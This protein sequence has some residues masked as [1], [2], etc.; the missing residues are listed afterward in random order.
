MEFVQNPAELTPDQPQYLTYQPANPLLTNLHA[1]H[2][3]TAYLIQTS[4]AA[5]L[6]VTGE[7]LPPHIEWKPNAF[8]F[9]GFHLAAGEEPTFGDYFG[10][11]PEFQNPDGTLGE[12]FVLNNATG[13]WQ[14]VIGTE[15]MLKGEGVWVYCRGSSQ[16]TGPFRL[17]LEQG[18]AL[19]FGTILTTQ[20]IELKNVG[21]PANPPLSLQ[22]SSA[23][24]ASSWLYY[25]VLD[26]QSGQGQWLPFPQ[27]PALSLSVETGEI[28]RLRLGVR[29][30]ALSAGEDIGTNLRIADGAGAEVL[31]PVSATGVDFSGLWVGQ[32][33]LDRVNEIHNAGDPETLKAAGS[34]FTFRL[35]LHVDASGATRLLNQVVQAWDT[36]GEAPVPMLV[37][38]PD[39]EA[40]G[41]LD[42]LFLRDGEPVGRRISAPAFG[43][44]LEPGP[45]EVYHKAMTGGAFGVDG[46]QLNVVLELPGDDP[47]HPFLHAYHPEHQAST[48]FAVTRTITLTFGGE[49]GGMAFIGWG[50]SDVGGEYREE[51]TGLTRGGLPVRVGG[52]FR[53][54]KV[55]GID[56][57]GGVP[58]T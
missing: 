2:G 42:S 38:D 48:G 29:R 13:Q 46:S 44:S 19:D 16:F 50:S 51:I 55:S 43:T 12:I 15:T 10:S 34:E 56:T 7:P 27:S 36:S 57:L 53:L 40:S 18:R 45:V 28:E 11:F 30:S 22:L 31:L 35:I 41:T 4:A 23:G 5:T 54:H 3:N 21:S 20:D 24:P 6:T 9:V 47:T 58:S 17:T 49:A 14:Q 33:I 37:A 1:I 25:W 26:P 8:N 52:R 32:V 39:L